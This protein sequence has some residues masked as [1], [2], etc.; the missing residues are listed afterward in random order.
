MTRHCK[1]CNK[2]MTKATKDVTTLTVDEK[3]F[4]VCNNCMRIITVLIENRDLFWQLTK[5]IVIEGKKLCDTCGQWYP[6]ESYYESRFH[7]DNKYPTCKSCLESQGIT[8]NRRDLKRVS[9]CRPAMIGDVE[10][11][12]KHE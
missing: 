5:Q 8:N 6:L 2:R 1:F 10:R 9:Q 12:K 11:I 7:T 3:L 4:V